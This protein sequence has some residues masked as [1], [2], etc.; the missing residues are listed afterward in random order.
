[1][2]NVLAHVNASESSQVIL[3]VSMQIARVNKRYVFVLIMVLQYVPAARGD[4]LEY[5]AA[6]SLA[7]T[8][9]DAT[10]DT[11]AK[12]LVRL[13][14]ALGGFLYI[15]ISSSIG[16]QLDASF[17]QRGADRKSRDTEEDLKGRSLSYTELSISS[18]FRI[19]LTPRQ[20]LYL[21]AGLGVGYLIDSNLEDTVTKDYDINMLASVGVSRMIAPGHS[22]S[23]G[24]GFNA[25]M[26][27][28]FPDDDGKI[29]NR[30]YLL[31]ISYSRNPQSDFD[32]DGILDR[33]ELRHCVRLA[34]DLDEVYDHDGCPETDHDGDRVLD[35]DDQ[36]DDKPED[37]DGLGDEDGCPEVDHDNDGIEDNVDNCPSEAFAGKDGCKPKYKH[38]S[39]DM[40]KGTL[41]LTTPIQFE[42][43][44]SK[45]TGSH[46]EVLEEIAR[47]LEDY[48]ELRLQ[49]RG[50][51]S[52]DSKEKGPDKQRIA[53]QA[54]SEKRASAVQ[55]FLVS[56]FVEKQTHRL[57]KTRNSSFDCSAQHDVSLQ[58]WKQEECM[59][60]ETCNAILLRITPKGFG[61]GERI[62]E[63]ETPKARAQNRRVDFKVITN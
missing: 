39:L 15:P 44:K 58:P 26:V 4:S 33:D 23:I 17:S 42:R 8:T 6:V 41:T 12:S 35:D 38:F 16:I 60:N 13:G 54:V 32:G 40:E 55:N 28:L 27:N 10:E 37:R 24:L 5:G 51:A 19:R 36:C 48:P 20:H 30:S 53:N 11:E 63:Q 31:M 50:H 1:M 52:G 47:A 18:Q 61:D 14:G 25:G 9:F 62:I 59:K 56:C 2:K 29:H 45:V 7:G 43:G 22:L 46:R 57:D 34:E 21:Q 3:S 49:V